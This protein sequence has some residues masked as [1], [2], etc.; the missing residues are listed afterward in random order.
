MK[1]TAEKLALTLGIFAVVSGCTATSNNSTQ[2]PESAKVTEV[3]NS[4]KVASVTVDGSSTVYPITQAIAQEFQANSKNNL[5]VQV[6]ISGTGGGFAKFCAGKTDI[7][8][9]SRPITQAEMADCNRNGIRYIELPVAFDALTIAVNPQND[10]AKDI[11]IAELKKIW[12]PGRK[13]KLPVGTKYGHLR[14]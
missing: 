11:T 3:A 6:N 7:N 4:T 9:A 2:S 5:Q 10:W 12:E 8:N 1:T 14:R 13:E